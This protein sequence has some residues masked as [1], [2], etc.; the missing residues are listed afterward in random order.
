MEAIEVRIDEQ[1]ATILIH[2]DDSDRGQTIMVSPDQIDTL[3]QW[4][5]EAKQEAQERYQTISRNT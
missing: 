3:I 1:D 4:L 5:E 2:Q